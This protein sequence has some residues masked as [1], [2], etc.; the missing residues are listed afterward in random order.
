MDISEILVIGHSSLK[1]IVFRAFQDIR[2]SDALENP[3]KPGF[4]TG[5]ADIIQRALNRFVQF[6]PFV[7]GSP[8]DGHLRNG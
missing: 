6:I 8:N 5:R 4:L 1:F 7:L 2:A 3:N